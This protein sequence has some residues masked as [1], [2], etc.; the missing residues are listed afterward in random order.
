MWVSQQLWSAEC[1]GG[2]SV[3]MVPGSRLLKEGRAGTPEGWHSVCGLP[4]SD[5]FPVRVG[6]RTHAY[7]ADQIK[8]YRMGL[9]KKPKVGLG[10]QQMDQSI[11]WI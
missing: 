10:S 8:E 9:K 5:C 7:Q 4:L 11:C 1:V 6:V 2:S 3:L